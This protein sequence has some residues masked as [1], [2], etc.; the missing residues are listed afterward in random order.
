VPTDFTSLSSVVL[1]AVL[2][3]NGTVNLTGSL[4][5]YNIT[6][7]SFLDLVS[8]PAVNKHLAFTGSA[9]TLFS[10]ANL[11]AAGTNFDNSSTSV[12]EVRVSGSSANTIVVGGVELVFS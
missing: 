11:L 9:P 8:A 7:G 1:R 12:Y 6:S 4:Q 3:T 10:S 2:A 5:V